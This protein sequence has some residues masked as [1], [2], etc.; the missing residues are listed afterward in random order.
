MANGQRTLND[1][2]ALRHM[3]TPVSAPMP[4]PMMPSMPTPHDVTGQF[5]GSMNVAAHARFGYQQIGQ[6]NQTSPIGMG[7][8]FAPDPSMMMPAGLSIFRPPP[9]PIP[10]PLRTTPG[11]TGAFHTPA[12]FATQ[13]YL[14]EAAAFLD[15][16]RGANILARRA[17]GQA[18]A[19]VGAGVG[20][21]AGGALTGGMGALKG[22][23][24]GSGLGELFGGFMADIPI[25]GGMMEYAQR[26]EAELLGG[27]AGMQF[28]TMGRVSMGRR[29]VGLGGRGIGAMPAFNLARNLQ[30]FSN[31]M[32]GVSAN[33][34]SGG[35]FNQTDI[36]NLVTASADAGLLDA[37]TNV[38]QIEG[39]VKKVMTLV[40]RLGRLTGDPDFRNNIRELG[41]M[42]QLGFEMD[43]AVDA[44]A[45]MGRY[46]V[47]AGMTR[48]QLMQQAVE[49]GMARFAAAGL[50]P[51]LGM[52]HGA[53]GAAAGGMMRGVGTPIQQALMGDP[54]QRITEANAAF[55]SGQARMLLPAL[56]G[57]EGGEV[58]LDPARIQALASSGSI[59]LR[60]MTAQG[61]QNMLDVAQRVAEQRAA[62][63]GRAVRAGEVRGVIGE[64]T[65]RQ[66]EF[67]SELGMQM[68]PEQVMRANLAM[69]MGLRRQGVE[70]WEALM[71]V[72]G[73]DPMQAE[74]LRRYATDPKV[75]ERR[76]TQLD[77][78]IKKA[79]DDARALGR[80][81]TAAF[82]EEYGVSGIYGALRGA[83]REV[84]AWFTDEYDV[85][86]IMEA[87]EEARAMAYREEAAASGTRTFRP[88][89]AGGGEVNQRIVERIQQRM[90]RTGEPVFGAE[91]RT[92]RLTESEAIRYQRMMGGYGT[93]MG[94]L[95]RSVGISPYRREEYNRL[96]GQAQRSVETINKAKKRTDKDQR[97]LEKQMHGQLR[98]WGVENIPRAMA[99]IKQ[100]VIDLA[101]ERGGKGA[102]TSPEDLERAFSEVL[103]DTAVETGG[104]VGRGTVQRFIEANKGLTQE[105]LTKIVIDEGGNVARGSL[106]EAEAVGRQIQ[107][108]TDIETLDKLEDH[109]EK[110]QDDL[111]EWL[112]KE[113]IARRERVVW[114]P[115]RFYRQ[116]ER[117]AFKAMRGALATGT[118]EEGAREM[119][120][121]ALYAKLE[122]G[123]SEEQEE[124]RATLEDMRLRA[125][126]AGDEKVLGQLKRVKDRVGEGA[127]GVGVEVRRGLARYMQA[128]EKAAGAEGPE[129]AIGMLKEA[130]AGKGPFAKM[131]TPERLAATAKRLPGGAKAIA[132]GLEGVGGL[133]VDTG[134]VTKLEEEKK[135]AEKMYKAWTAPGGVG[136]KF[137]SGFKSLSTAI[138][139]LRAATSNLN[140]VAE[141]LKG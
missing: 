28:G 83:A 89:V 30:Q 127:G 9:T 53:F 48:T 39:T 20:A 103:S 116:S 4:Q 40:G 33:A 57:A 17:A 44:L 58:R 61:R 131:F 117:Q 65:S 7:G 49:P 52:Q 25:L 138:V 128:I 23:S 35:V 63:E 37:A 18:G 26:E 137:D 15:P 76:L 82:R 50:A 78:Q 104:T 122:T 46:G 123:T 27:M 74:A 75:H 92:G 81:R 108:Y 60:E 85:E 120:L 139:D 107:G 24:W 54:G 86:G 16:A 67:L 69:A 113:G 101:R 84:G 38:D 135:A 124:A 121:T 97:S 62:S 59:N 55:L 22:A 2:N 140:N 47:A 114:D 99:A 42:K 72:T 31:Q 119:Y 109:Q 51:G 32:A 106:E 129:A 14:G 64:M 118:E 11:V 70:P 56:F 94:W 91:P 71:S 10:P 8:Q 6:F 100:R 132:E 1:L 80:G 98:E 115:D 36:R 141:K 105:L 77:Q 19:Y 126:E 136:E 41:R 88:M 125:E 3:N 130:I 95:Q 73:G 112:N 68:R 90:E 96:M 66:Q 5:F 43:Q 102:A 12:N 79:E 87:E 21:L 110:V 111:M 93:A 133:A 45:G 34:V 29:D 134:E 13:Q